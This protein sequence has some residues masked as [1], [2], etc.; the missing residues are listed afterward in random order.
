VGE[1]EAVEIVDPRV[2][3]AA[4]TLLKERGWSHADPHLSGSV[5]MTT[6]LYRSMPHWGFKGL[7]DP[8]L[9]LLHAEDTAYMGVVKEVL[10]LEPARGS[11]RQWED[12]AGRT[13]AEIVEA[14]EAAH[15]L[16]SERFAS[17]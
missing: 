5:N 12:A 15:R 9:A 13:Y 14:L 16:A 3:S 10:G 11:L 4:L 7:E 17:G 8:A 2:F 6:A 1:T